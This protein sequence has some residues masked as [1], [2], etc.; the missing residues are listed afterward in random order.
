MNW[1]MKLA[2]MLMLA[3]WVPATMHCS[4]EPLPAFDFLQQCCSDED[5]HETSDTCCSR[6]FCQTV[7]SGLYKIEDQPTLMPSTFLPS[8]FNVPALLGEIASDDAMPRPVRISISP[9]DHVR[10]WQFS[11]RAALSPRAPSSLV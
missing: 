10:T 5:S 1:L 6:D 8:A 7:E 2:A 4:L 3:L 11:Q 9:P